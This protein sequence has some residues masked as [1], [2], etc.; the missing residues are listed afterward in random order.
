MHRTFV[1]LQLPLF[2]FV[3]YPLGGGGGVFFFL[4]YFG[5]GGGERNLGSKLGMLIARETN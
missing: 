1:G 4:C 5:M 2:F 3:T